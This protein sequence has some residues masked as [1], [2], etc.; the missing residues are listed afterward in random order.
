VEAVGELDDD[1]A[2]VLGHGEE[3]LAEVFGLDVVLAGA[4][5]GGLLGDLG[6]LGDALD[7]GGDFGA[8][9]LADLLVGDAAVLLDVV[10]EGTGDGA[11]I[12][13]EGGDGLGGV[14]WVSDH[15]VTAAAGLA[16]VFFD[17]V[18]EGVLDEVHAFGR[19]VF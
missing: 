3:H 11:G 5:L 16:V 13:L 18:G 2:E 12:H 6:E 4:G 9:A 7:H 15:G 17:G 8:E 10:E 14:E 19:E 1:D